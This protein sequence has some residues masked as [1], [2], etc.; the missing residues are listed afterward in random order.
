VWLLAGFE[1]VAGLS[2]TRLTQSLCVKAEIDSFMNTFHLDATDFGINQAKSSCSI[3][4]VDGVL[5]LNV[6]VRGDDEKYEAITENEDSE[7]SWTLYPPRLY[8]HDFPLTDDGGIMCANISRD[9]LETYEAAIYLIEHNDLD[10]VELTV[11]RDGVLKIRGTVF[12]SG[13]PHKFSVHYT[14]AQKN[15]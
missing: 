10:S 3:D 5:V 12:L 4:T 9:D 8:I 1:M 7:W 11:D 13:R 2:H 6:E 15:A 14:G